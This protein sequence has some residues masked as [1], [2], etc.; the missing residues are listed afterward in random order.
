MDNALL[1]LFA[2][3]LV[4]LN[5]FFVAAEFAIVKLR[6]TQAEELAEI[7]GLPG[8]I[9][10]TVSS[11]LDAYLSACQLGIT[12][13]SLGLGWVGEP[14]FARLLELIHGISFAFAFGLISF[15]HIVIGELVPKSMAIRKPETMS[16][17]TATPLYLF[18]WGMYPFIRF[19]NASAN[20]VLRWVGVGMAHES[21]GVHSLEEIKKVLMASH[22]HGELDRSEAE[23]LARALDLPELEVGDFMRPARDLVMLDLEDPLEHHLQLIHETHYSRYPVYEGD[24]QNILGIVHIKDL[25]DV[26][27]RKQTIDLRSLL[28]P[29]MHVHRDRP[30]VE[31]FEQLRRGDARMVIV[32]NDQGSMVGFVTLTH[33]LETLHGP[34]H[35]EYQHR[36][37][38]WMRIA[39][40]VYEGSGSLP[41]YSLERLLGIELELEDPD[42]DSV[43]GM[44]ISQLGQIPR[45]GDQAD[46]EHF[47]ID[48]LAMER[49]R[50]LSVRISVKP[51]EDG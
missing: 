17:W 27:A 46:F 21:E 28:R 23:T 26:L 44:V 43:A 31:L 36:K 49:A 37:D 15:L 50:V 24:R 38:E 1:T 5:G 8:R 30:G 34:I 25:F 41:I 48:V 13:A 51:P 2:L 39:D 11:Q 35:D 22:R 40:G 9:L 7:H 47:T 32:E 42:V 12:L 14:A 16:L 3:F 20:I 29:V 6:Y 4:L 19:L 10:R 45:V 33:V 18:Y